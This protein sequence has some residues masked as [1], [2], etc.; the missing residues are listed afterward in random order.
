MQFEKRSVM[1]GEV[2]A[3]MV[4]STVT[5]NGWV[6][7]RRDHGNLIFVDVRDRSGMV[8]AVLSPELNN[9]AYAAAQNLHNEEVISLSG[10]VVKR[11]AGGQNPQW[12]TGD[13]EIQGHALQI[14]NPVKALPF[15][16]E[17]ER[18][19]EELRL[20]Y[21][22]LDLR[23]PRMFELLKLRS[24]I[25]FA[26]REFFHHEGFLDVATPI[27]TKNTPEGA[28]EF[29]SPSRIQKGKFYA[30]PQSPQLYKQLLMAS[31]IDR[32]YQIAHCFRDEDLRADRQPEFMQLDLEMSFIDE[33]DIQTTI[34]RLIQF[35]L[36]KV[37]N[38]DLTIPFERMAYDHAFGQYGSDKPDV[39]FELK[40]H[41]ISSAFVDTQVNFLKAALA[42]GKIGAL[43]VSDY[44]FSRSELDDLVEKMKQQGAQGL[45]W[46]TCAADG[47]LESPIAK[48]LPKDFAERIRPLVAGFKPGD[49]LLIMAG[50]F[51]DT[52]TMLGRLRVMLGKKL[53]LIDESMQSYL[54]VTDFPMFEY[55]KETNTYAAMHHPFT[56]PQPGW[57]GRP[58]GE[59][60]A[61]AY[62]IVLNGVELGGGSIRI[63]NSAEQAKVFQAIG[64]T[65]ESAEKR[66]GFLLEAQKLGF[67]PHGG[68]AIGIDRFIM[69]LAKCDSIREVTAFPKTAKGVDPLMQAPVE[70]EDKDLAEYGLMRKKSLT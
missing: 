53:G 43:C 60:K 34:E 56:M 5:V 41:D 49:T 65:Q 26:M 33:L 35:T 21:R 48:F 2:T 32:Y 14:L 55:D 11:S 52:W 50:D 29:V 31:G 19:D 27:L 69:L 30:L 36:K 28:R 10:T 39:R 66:F 24:D 57:E 1:C 58:Y 23:R 9:D 64:L 4:D 16:L 22:Y 8:Q 67:P 63:F 44:H 15:Q 59:V 70:L 54:W 37:F 12:T 46:I 20:K 40:I 61:R 51:Q 47:S 38:R 6:N 17:D 62:D 42:H 45:L 13:I 25:E 18:V 3:S 68:L 7:R